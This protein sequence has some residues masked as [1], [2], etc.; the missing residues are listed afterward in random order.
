M[1]QL[2]LTKMACDG[3]SRI[4]YWTRKNRKRVTRKLELKK[5]CRWCR[6]HV[7]HTEKKK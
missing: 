3:C 5:F 6:K 7:D 4:N 2:H 1:A